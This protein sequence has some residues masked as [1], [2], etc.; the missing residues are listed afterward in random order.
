MSLTS[1]PEDPKDY[2]PRATG[3]WENYRQR[4][5]NN[6]TRM[7]EHRDRTLVYAG[8]TMKYYTIAKG[9]KP[10][11]GYPLYIALHGGGGA[12]AGVNNSAWER[13]Q[14]YYVQ[15]IHYGIYVA[16]RGITDTWDMHFRPESYVF[17]DRLIENMILFEDVN[18][19][20]VYLLGYSAGGDG[21]Y[22]V[23][24]RMADRFAAVNMS[25]GHHNSVDFRNL[26]NLPIALQAGQHDYAYNRNI[27]TAKMNESLDSLAREY[28][29]S[30]VHTTWIHADKGHSFIDNNPDDMPHKVFDNPHNWL[31]L[32]SSGI[33]E[34]N[35]N[36]VCWLGQ[37]TRD[38]RPKR[39]IWDVTTR[40]DREGEGFWSCNGHGQQH[41]WVD[42]G[43]HT[44]DTLGVETI[45]VELERENNMVR[46]E[47]FGRYLRLL[48]DGYMLDFE[49]PVKI[50]ADGQIKTVSVRPSQDIQLETVKQRGDPQYIF[51]SSITI[52][53]TDDGLYVTTP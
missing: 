22:Q 4:E 48:V 20:K 3:V 2:R 11:G 5:R 46:V 43:N 51:D 40:A 23:A 45:I 30:Y 18:S 1:I 25:A 49:Q 6:E 35:T 41:Y 28:L 37:F 42:I 31:S 15:S 8:K 50:Q 33:S 38:P 32:G 19:D 29:G 13:M 7:Q 17:Y 39:V 14:S 16:P 10:D 36:A 34:Q 21:V 44:A 53:R 52:I 47:K 26:A 12:P 27:E 24:P 9:Q